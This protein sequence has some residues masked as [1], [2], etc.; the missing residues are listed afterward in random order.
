MD[1]MAFA[2]GQVVGVALVLSPAV[3]VGGVIGNRLFDA[4]Q[5]RRYR[6]RIEALAAQYGAAQP[7][8][9]AGVRA[10]YFEPFTACC[11]CPACAGV[12]VHGMDANDWW[13]WRDCSGCGFEWPQRK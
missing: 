2:L 1:D 10:R 6:R 3:L 4:V 13:V 8:D 11:E 7:Q 12:A 9:L 5:A